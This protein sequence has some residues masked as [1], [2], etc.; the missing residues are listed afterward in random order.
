MKLKL[1]KLTKVE[2]HAFSLYQGE[3]DASF[4]CIDGATCL[5][6]ANGVGKSTLLN[7][8][9]YGFTGIVPDPSRA[10]KSFDEYY[11][12]CLSYA[13]RYFD[14]RISESDREAAAITLHFEC[15]ERLY[16]LTR[17][18][19]DPGEVDELEITPELTKEQAAPDDPAITRREKQLQYEKCICSDSGFSSFSQFACFQHFVCNFDEKRTLLLYSDKLVEQILNTVFLLEPSLAVEIDALRR[20][21]EKFDSQVRNIQWEITKNIK[22]ISDVKLRSENLKDWHIRLADLELKYKSLQDQVDQETI[23]RDE[24]Y[25]KLSDMTL[26]LAQLSAKEASLRDEFS[27]KMSLISRTKPDVRQ[28][29]T[30]LKM[31]GEGLCTLCGTQSGSLQERAT[32]LL[33]QQQ[34][35]ICESQ[36]PAPQDVNETELTQ[37]KAV[38]AQ[39]AHIRKSQHDTANGLLRE[40]ARFSSLD[41]K[42]RNSQA[43]L[44]E[45]EV[46][47]LTAITAL[48]NSVAS[49]SQPGSVDLAEDH[50]LIQ[51][52]QTEKSEAERS[53][54]EARERL[55][56]LRRKLR[57]QFLELEDKFVP[58]FR[59]LA[60]TFLGVD[61]GIRLDDS[62]DLIKLIISVRGTNRREEF[63]LSESQKFFLDIAFRMAL[64]QFVST[65]SAPSTLI[66]D[67]PE[68]SLD[69]AY[70]KR[71]GTMLSKF[72]AKNN[73]V[74][75]S[76]NLNSSQLLLALAKACGKSKMSLVYIMD[77]AALSTVQQDEVALFDVAKSKVVA[78]L[79]GEPTS[80]A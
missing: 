74:L 4:E 11:A 43:Q 78:A 68:G 7:A 50:L 48:R 1:P 49:A 36:L 34:C 22:R 20:S 58:L 60:H 18:L 33:S 8:I 44:S 64:L 15:N 14:G 79:A 57:S 27:E 23:E 75:M 21:E 40:Q 52:L 13:A 59:E 29:T 2:L 37:L 31:T 30:V 51:T 76:A 66:L 46:Q 71:A 63:K 73:R 77:W 5:V 61:I 24:A 39:L 69:I 38:D 28:Q 19:F 62:S 65:E 25:G 26:E 70:E 80:G 53:R 45:F 17:K 55:A 72:V 47:S 67:T 3:P 12:R 32:R 42:L 6:G 10:F 41:D 9:S 56:E 54:T 35:P 16:R